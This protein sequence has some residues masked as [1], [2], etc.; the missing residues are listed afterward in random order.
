[1]KVFDH[2]LSKLY[3]FKYKNLSAKFNLL[4]H[5]SKYITLAICGELSFP[6]QQQ[7]DG[8]EYQYREEWQY[9][10]TVISKDI[11]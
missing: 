7:Q 5:W 2:D 6:R 11:D 8:F 1:M 9:D 10:L 4:P 3:T